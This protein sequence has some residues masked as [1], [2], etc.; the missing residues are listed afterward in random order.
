MDS[1][2][3]R[4][5][6]A[7]SSDNWKFL[8]DANPAG[9]CEDWAVTAGQ[10]LLDMGYSIGALG[11]EFGYLPLTGAEVVGEDGRIHPIGH[12]W[13]S[14]A[15]DA[16]VKAIHN[17]GIT[18]RAALREQYAME[19]CVQTSGLNWRKLNPSKHDPDKTFSIYPWPSQDLEMNVAQSPDATIEKC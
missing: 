14:V 7:M 4:A 9:D 6:E 2:Y 3:T 10:L 1:H 5:N 13:L 17:G 18:T 11:L 16:G 12:M 8:T 19:A 15:T